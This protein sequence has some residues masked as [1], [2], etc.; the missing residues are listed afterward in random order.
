MFY[1]SKKLIDEKVLQQYYFEKLMLAKAAELKKLIPVEYHAYF[2]SNSDIKCL[3][4]EVKI[5]GKKGN[6]ITDFVLYPSCSNTVL[7]LNIEIKWQKE[8]FNK[9]LYSYY[10]G[11]HSKGF[12]VCFGDTSN[13]V[14]YD[15]IG[16]SKKKIPVIYLDVD[17]FKKWFLIN[18]NAIISQALSSRLNILPQRMT[19]KK[20]WVVAINRE[21]LNHYNNFGKPKNIWAFRYSNIPKNIISILRGDYVVF[22]SFSDVKPAARMIYP[23]YDETYK[24]RK[25]RGGYTLSKHVDWTLSFAD[26][27]MID[28]GYH[29]D[30]SNK[31]RY[32]CFEKY[33]WN[34]LPETKEYTQFITFK[35]SKNDAFQ[36][37]W[38]QNETKT[39]I[40]RKHFLGKDK[41]SKEIVDAFSTSLNNRGD[42]IEIT[43][44]AFHQFRQII[45]EV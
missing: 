1:N 24:I 35:H 28:K 17:E 18:S 7:K 3:H 6:H 4:P 23:H 34:G 22:V 31:E 29:L 21:A 9:E 32:K 30:F 25:Q 10:D 37:R 14:F 12:V 26:V 27:F 36:Y 43:A 44:E 5:K 45:N 38:N 33:N 13:G 11:T 40:S 2:K 15:Y 16:N 20:Y 39:K 8:A 42:A 19:G 41:Y